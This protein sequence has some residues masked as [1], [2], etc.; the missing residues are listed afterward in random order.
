MLCSC[1]SAGHSETN[2]ANSMKQI[3]TLIAFSLITF[4]CCAQTT[5]NYPVPE[6]SNEIYFFNK[7]AAHLT[8]LEKGLSKMESKTKMGGMGG[9]ETSYSIEGT[10]SPNRIALKTPL[11]FVYFTGEGSAPGASA[12]SIMK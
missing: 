4:V 6:Y 12:D 1:L 11:D 9:G 7:D 10:R 8:R 5:V 2:Q 3:I